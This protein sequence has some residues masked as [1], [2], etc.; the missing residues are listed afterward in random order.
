MENKID[1]ESRADYRCH[2]F[3]GQIRG[4]CKMYFVTT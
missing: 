1:L 2:P 4:Y 3:V